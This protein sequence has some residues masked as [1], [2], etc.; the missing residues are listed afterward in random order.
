[1]K[2]IRPHPEHHDLHG[3]TVAVDTGGAEVYVGRC[4]DIDKERVYLVD[5]D[6]HVDGAHGLS[7][8]AWLEQV[9]KFGHW[10][11]HERLALARADVAWIE[12]LGTIA[13]EGPPGAGDR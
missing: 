2:P 1:M 10:K 7:K 8:R 9:A 5:V 11:K 12:T 6:V 13:V 4:H 3:I